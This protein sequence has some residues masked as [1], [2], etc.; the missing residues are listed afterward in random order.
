MALTVGIDSYVTLEEAETYFGNRLYAA[1]WTG[2]SDPEK[3]KALKMAARTMMRF[4]WSGSITSDDQILSWPRQGMI[5]AE[6]RVIASDAIPQIIKDAQCEVALG[7]LRDDLT[8]DDG[9]KSVRKLKAG[10]VEI[11][12]AGQAP[13]A[14]RAPDIAI[15]MVKPFLTAQTGAN[16]SMVF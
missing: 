5:D 14:A 7:M 11:E 9:N 12:Y 16:A 10:S 2:A 8:A 15:D 6:G 4:N 3:E 1:E 13:A